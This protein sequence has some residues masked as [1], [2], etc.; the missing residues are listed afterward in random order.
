MAFYV[1]T[2]T[3]GTNY[4]TIGEGLVD[5]SLGVSLV[6]QN[7]HNYG[8]LI[9]NNF[10]RMLEHHANDT[11][12]LNPQQGQIWWN[13]AKK[14]LGVFDGANF[15]PCTGTNVNT[16]PPVNALPGEQWWNTDSNQLFA[17]TGTA[18]EIIGPTN[19]KGT[20]FT[21]WSPEVV[22]DV[23][24]LP[25]T[26]A[27][28]Q[29]DGVTIG[30]ASKDTEFLLATPIG[31]ISTVSKGLT[32]KGNTLFAGT[33]TNATSLGGFSANSYARLDSL[34]NTFAGSIFVKGLGG[35]FVGATSS[36]LSIAE[37]NIG[38]HIINSVTSN[39][40][41][42][43]GSTAMTWNKVADTITISNQPT[44][45]ASVANKGYVDTSLA[46]VDSGIRAYVDSRDNAII[47]G[48]PIPT[49][50]G[51]SDALGADTNYAVNAKAYVDGKIY[52]TDISLALKANINSPVLTGAPKAPT[53]TIGDNTT[54]VATTAFVKSTVDA[55]DLLTIKG[56]MIPGLPNLDIG[57]TGNR[58]RTVFGTAIKAKYADLAET[59]LSDAPYLPGTV[60][61]L[62]GTAEVTVSDQECDT[63]V[64]GVISTDPAYLM[65]DQK[66]GIPVALTGKVPCKVIGPI[67][68]GDLLVNSE[69]AGIAKV[70]PEGKWKPGC[71]IGKSFENNDEPGIRNIM[72][73]VGRF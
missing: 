19:T 34:T 58:F 21:G 63:R 4:T 35:M 40:V 31:D 23:N 29:V 42:S 50:K 46:T 60:V 3:N 10:L 53:P 64:A 2:H 68:K 49:L 61:V 11:P 30:L 72:I 43:S 56:V 47:N 65:N 44:V 7:Y 55:L 9:A 39:V 37:E 6:G 5:N 69:F 15:K 71:I 8:Q 24:G 14:E 17:Y 16:S 18:W 13:S 73:S 52:V 28:M 32:L 33:A 57:T 36:P 70:L 41:V 25:H 48:S 20:A 66:M 54:N 38:T 59:L 12:P 26:I 62:G 67:K 51:L 27:S 22:T 1:V 45:A